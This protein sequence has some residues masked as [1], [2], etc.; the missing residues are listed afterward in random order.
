VRVTKAALLASIE[1]ALTNH[2]AKAAKWAEAVEWHKKRQLELWQERKAPQ[3]KALRDLLTKSLKD[4]KP[5]TEAMVTSVLT[6][7]GRYHSS[8]FT[9]HTYNPEKDPSSPIVMGGERIYR[10][11]L[12]ERPDML[13]LRAFLEQSPDEEFSLTSLARLGFKAP[14]YVFREAANG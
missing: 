1:K 13:G 12:P 8:Y 9:D 3:W 2:D 14:S 11:H 6:R 5:I 4:G 10:P 7:E